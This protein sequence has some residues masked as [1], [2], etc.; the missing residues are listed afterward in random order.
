L[1]KAKG[2][3]FLLPAAYCFP[4]SGFRSSGGACATPAILQAEALENATVSGALSYK[5]RRHFED[6]SGARLKVLKISLNL[7]ELEV[8]RKDGTLEQI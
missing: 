4:L 8:L 2:C 1:S 5:Q 6:G 7:M 3:G